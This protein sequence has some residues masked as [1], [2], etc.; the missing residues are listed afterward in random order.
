MR[1]QVALAAF[2]A[3][4]MFAVLACT[5]GSEESV[6]AEEGAIEQG[7]A[8]FDHLDVND[9]GGV[10]GRTAA[11]DM[12]PSI[13][14]ASATGADNA[15]LLPKPV[16]DQM[17][18][19]GKS[20]KISGLPGGGGNHSI[21]FEGGV[22]D[23]KNWKVTGW[24]FDPCATNP[25]DLQ[26]H[27]GKPTLTTA[28]DKAALDAPFCVVQLRLIV[29]PIVNGQDQD[30]TMHLVYGVGQGST[31]ARDAIVKD[32]LALKKAA[33][34][35]DRAGKTVSVT[36]GVP[37]GVHPGLAATG[38]VSQ[39]LEKLF[40]THLSAS[41]LAAV[42]FMGL[43]NFGFEPWTFYAGTVK[44]GAWTPVPIPA[45]K[46][47]TIQVQ[48]FRQIGPIG[49]FPKLGDAIPNTAKF[50]DDTPPTSGD[51]L[52]AVDN[53]EETN[54]FTT[55]C[56]SCHTASQRL[57]SL[58]LSTSSAKRFTVPKGV[59]AFVAGPDAQGSSWNVRNCGYFNGTPSVSQRTANESAEAVDAINRLLIPAITPGKS[60]Q[61]PGDD[62]SSQAVFDCFMAGQSASQCAGLCKTLG[63]SPA[64]PPAQDGLK[65][66]VA[67]QK[68]DQAARGVE[69]LP[70]GIAP[71]ATVKESEAGRS[72]VKLSVNDSTCLSQFL[73]S[74]FRSKAKSPT[75]KGAKTLQPNVEIA[76]KSTGSCTALFNLPPDALKGFTLDANDS[77]TLSNLIA[78][79]DKKFTTVNTGANGLGVT[80]DCSTA[81]AC[82]V[83]PTAK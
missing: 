1:S 25:Q 27:G 59:T 22:N 70:S 52:H 72:V 12:I 10:L 62:C 38:A 82:K 60:A 7:A 76:C 46:D 29:Q 16:F 71:P 40:K 55:D 65:D 33:G 17:V 36:T 26:A 67:C 41:K 13:A 43:E 20:M 73:S 83:E 31:G 66:I 79:K 74:S 80:V 81:T 68:R 57:G 69:G 44:D 63:D 19:F 28:T 14:V 23:I 49:V 3:T 39:G 9:I 8:A 2:A 45:F 56:V 77:K 24:R 35:S 34:T 50:F 78:T 15:P 51:A 75:A 6:G 61:N 32:L 5:S 4:T 11:G 21:A 47:P 18:A 53:P 54:F 48:T 42:A 58:G 64:D 30:F 37:L